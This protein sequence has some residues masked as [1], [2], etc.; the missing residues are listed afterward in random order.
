MS[1]ET[2]SVGDINFDDEMLAELDEPDIVS[3]IDS[4]DVLVS[5]VCRAFGIAR[6]EL[7]T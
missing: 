3:A 6:Y 4:A 2:A 1:A 7:I 5:V